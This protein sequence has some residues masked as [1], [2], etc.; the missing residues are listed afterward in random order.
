MT[1][2]EIESFLKKSLE[3]RRLSRNERQALGSLIADLGPGADRREVVHRAFESARAVLESERDR[4]ILDWL[5]G[6]VK[7]FRDELEEAGEPTIAEAHFSPGE[8]CLRAIR[9]LLGNARTTVDACVFTITDDRLANALIDTHQRGVAVRIITD[10]SKAEDFG[11]D[12]DRL[13]EAG[14]PIRV[15]RSPFHMHHKFA[16]VDGSTLLTGSYNWTRGA[17][18]ENEENLI[19]TGEPRLVSPFVSTFDDLWARLG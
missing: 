6:V 19:V 17:A 1:P 3:D 10:D 5:E 11:S 9:G 16:V 14:I 7:G 12:V 18:N 2:A 4:E 8:D 13:A 15:D